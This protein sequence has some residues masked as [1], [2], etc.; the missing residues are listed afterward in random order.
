LHEEKGKVAKKL[1]TNIAGFANPD[2]CLSNLP[3]A[4]TVGA[5]I[6][7]AVCTAMETGL[8][9]HRMFHDRQMS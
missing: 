2:G 6:Y 3:A 1:E 9:Y 7:H 5:A 4:A 8:L